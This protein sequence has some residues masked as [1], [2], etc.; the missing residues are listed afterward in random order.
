MI[1]TRIIYM[2]KISVTIYQLIDRFFFNRTY[3][4]WCIGCQFQNKINDENKY[5]CFIC[6]LIK[7]YETER[8]LIKYINLTP[9]AM[10]VEDY[11]IIN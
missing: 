7:L 5:L 3:D 8:Y 10:T 6:E 2:L 9:V 11:A 4:I 1:Y